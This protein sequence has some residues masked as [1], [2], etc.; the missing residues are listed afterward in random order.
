MEIW[1]DGQDEAQTE[2]YIFTEDG[3]VEQK[4]PFHVSSPGEYSIITVMYGC[5][6]DEE[7]EE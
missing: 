3:N 6:W 7:T 1:V 5:I 4:F 2:R